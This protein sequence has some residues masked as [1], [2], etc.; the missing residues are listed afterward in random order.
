MNAKIEPA[1]ANRSSAPDR[2]GVIALL[3]GAAIIAWSG[4][5]VRFLDEGL[6]SVAVGRASV[7]LVALVIL[8][9]PPLF[10][11]FRLGQSGRGDDRA[12]DDRRRNRTRLRAALPSGYGDS[13]DPRSAERNSA[14]MTRMFKTASSIGN[15]RGAFPA[16]ARENASPCSV[17]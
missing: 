9:Q 17:Y 12:A 6:T 15:S 13:H 3:V 11:A 16:I 4:I 1:T 2:V 14:S 5:L 8:A 10:G 7:G